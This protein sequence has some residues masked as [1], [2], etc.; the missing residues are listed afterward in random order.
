MLGNSWLSHVVSPF[1]SVETVSVAHLLYAH[2]LSKDSAPARKLSGHAFSVSDPNPPIAFADLYNALASLSC[3]HTKFIC[4]PA[5]PFLLLA[6]LVEAYAMLQSRLPGILP[7]LGGNLEKLQ[8]SSFLVS[9]PHLVIDCSEAERSVEDGGL[10]L[11]APWGSL[12]GFARQLL[13]CNLEHGA[14]KIW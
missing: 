12:T 3:T 1:V 7:K 11:K 2:H 6:H 10:G 8:P 13:E 5:V 4:V 9:H 14:E